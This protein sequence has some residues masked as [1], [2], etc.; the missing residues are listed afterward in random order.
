MLL[1]NL[2]DLQIYL[3]IVREFGTSF[4]PI[5]FKHLSHMKIT[6]EEE[7]HYSSTKKFE[8]KYK[9]CTHI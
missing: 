6:I 2:N 1:S 4:Q 5:T 7:G 8:L 3:F 9:L